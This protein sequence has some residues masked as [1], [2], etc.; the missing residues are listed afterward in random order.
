[1]A[2]AAGAACHAG[3]TEPS[4]VLRSMH[5]PDDLALSTLRLSVGRSTTRE[6]IDVAATSIATAAGSLR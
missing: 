3:T 5:V 4:R 1:M 2:A 6:E